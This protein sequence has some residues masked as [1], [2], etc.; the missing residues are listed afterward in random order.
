MTTL[1]NNRVSLLDERR[2][3]AYARIKAEMEEW[4]DRIDD[5]TKDIEKLDKVRDIKT[6]SIKTGCLLFSKKQ[7]ELLHQQNKIYKKDLGHISLE[8]W[9]V[10]KRTIKQHNSSII[11]KI[12]DDIKKNKKEEEKIWRHGDKEL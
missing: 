9:N 12:N 4:N 7:L 2:A 8:D 11:K 10:F 6:I 5:T 3:N 1:N